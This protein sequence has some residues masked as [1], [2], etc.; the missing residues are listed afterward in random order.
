MGSPKALLHIGGRTALEA[1]VSAFAEA[2]LS[3]VIVVANGEV[4][5]FAE[6]LP[7]VV[8]V[9]GDPK[10]PMVDSYA[11]GMEAAMDDAVAV[12][13]QPVDAPFTSAA[14]VAALLA[15]DVRVPRVLCHEGRPGHPVLLPTSMFTDIAEGPEGGVRALLASRDVEL[16]E[17]PDSRILA[18]LDTPADF[19]RWRSVIDGALH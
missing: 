17:W 4:L 2:G 13:A 15:G 8:V 18:D 1:V 16:V 3:P 5:S 11:R 7:D 14:M 10:A 19:G 6:S 12:V 9:A